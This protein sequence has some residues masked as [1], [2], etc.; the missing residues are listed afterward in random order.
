MRW[1][2]LIIILIVLISLSCYGGKPNIATYMQKMT[3]GKMPQYLYYEGNVEI[4]GMSGTYKMGYV[5]PSKLWVDMKTP[6]INVFQMIDDSSGMIVQNGQKRPMGS[7][8]IN[9]AK[10]DMF[11]TTMQWAQKENIDKFKYLGDNKWEYIISSQDTV[12][13][14]F[15][16]EGYL[17][18]SE[19]STVFGTATTVYDNYKEIDGFQI[20]FTVKQTVGPQVLVI[21]LKE[22]KVNDPTAVLFEETKETANWNPVDIKFELLG[23]HIFIDGKINGHKARLLLDTGAGMTIIDKKFAQN[24]NL[25]YEGEL[26]AIGMGE[27][28]QKG[29]L[30]RI[31]VKSGNGE[32]Q[33]VL[34]A[35]IDMSSIKTK[36]SEPIDGVIGYNI[37]GNYMLKIDWDNYVIHFMKEM[38]KEKEYIAYPLIM[39][40]D[41]PGIKVNINGQEYIFRIDTGAGIS[42]IANNLPVEYLEQKADILMSGLGGERKGRMGLI[43][44]WKIGRTN[45][46]PLEGV[47]IE[48]KYMPASFNGILGINWVMGEDI[49]IDYINHKLWIRKK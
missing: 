24:I 3:N 2:I 17:I 27:N 16:D 13:L 11:I 18:K 1:Y 40:F 5:Y 10:R 32:W 49:I 4:A 25:Q 36:I 14:T 39:D 9:M 41:L 42:I 43:K 33:D 47:V 6:L 35:V 20:P 46:M 26:P 22:V 23:G 21:N 15:S 45:M 30:S 28:I 38:K 7:M 37:I 12:Y 44:K 29:G 8:E 31:T 19:T 48:K 34:C